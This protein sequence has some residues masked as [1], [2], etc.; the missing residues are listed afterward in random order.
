MKTNLIIGV[1]NLYVET[2]FLGVETNGRDEVTVGN[3]YSAPAYETHLGGSAVNFITQVNKYG[4]KSA[5]IG[6]CGQDDNA[7]I[8]LRMLK[9]EGINT[10]LIKKSASH[11][12]NIDTG[13]IFSH[14]SQNIQFVAGNANQSLSFEDIDWNSP[15][16]DKAWGV[17]FG[18]SFKQKNLW[19]KYPDIFEMLNKKGIKLFLDAGRVPVDASPEWVGILNEILPSTF[20]YLPND[21]E[22]MSVTGKDSVMEALRIIKSSGVKLVAVK[23]GPEGCIVSDESGTYDL[24]AIEVKAVNTVGAGDCFNASLISAIA[25]GNNLEEA[26][27]FA[28]AAAA[29]RVSKNYQPKKE[30]VDE[31]LSQQN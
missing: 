7:D 13:L 22:I 23:K 25:T 11:L 24:P 12:T 5:I 6:K 14:S 10:D 1:G 26:G 8:L 9:Q 30:E 15:I 28:N 19:P 3:E 2:N 4:L 18:G 27:K 17:Y 21:K 29:F 31:F 20:G 16:F